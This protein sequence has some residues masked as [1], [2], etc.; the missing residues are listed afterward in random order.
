MQIIMNV[1]LMLPMDASKNVL[2]PVVLTHVNATLAL[3]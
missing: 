1:S 2:T 3:Y